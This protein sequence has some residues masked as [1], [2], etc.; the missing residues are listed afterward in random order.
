MLA[1]GALSKMNSSPA[2]Y[3]QSLVEYSQNLYLSYPTLNSSQINLDISRTF[4]D[5]V[6]FS[7]NSNVGKENIQ[8]IKRVCLA[9]S[10]R[11]SVIGYC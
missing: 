3:Y 6:Y 1:S 2:D 10:V 5:E 9:Y 11:N 7:Q 8:H 4:G